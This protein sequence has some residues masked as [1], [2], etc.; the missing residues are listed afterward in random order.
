MW[1]LVI[2]EGSV[3][4]LQDQWDLSRSHRLAHVCAESRRCPTGKDPQP[5]S[6]AKALWMAC[7]S[8]PGSGSQITVILDW[9][10][11]SGIYD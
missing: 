1:R 8:A 4:T 7:G 3:G 9:R 10:W 2:D 11:V 6:I 5:N